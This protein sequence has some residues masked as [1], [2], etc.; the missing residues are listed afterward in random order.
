M[1]AWSLFSA[2]IM[3]TFPMFATAGWEIKDRSKKEPEATFQGSTGNA[4]VFVSAGENV[5]VN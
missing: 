5:A 2:N 1:L 4:D 3:A